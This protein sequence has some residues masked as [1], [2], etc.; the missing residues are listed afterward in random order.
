[1]TMSDPV[2]TEV[3]AQPVRVFDVL[4]LGPV[5][6]L[7]AAQVKNPLYRAVLALGGVGTIVYNAANYAKIR[8][9]RAVQT[10]A[11]ARARTIRA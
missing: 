11:R 10:A 2:Y 1:M 9:R 8:R 4:I 3:K 6:V 5:M 7:A